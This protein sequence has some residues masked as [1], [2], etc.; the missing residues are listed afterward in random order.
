MCIILC[1]IFSGNH[2]EIELLRPKCVDSLHS[3]SPNT[4]ICS[5]KFL[6]L[7]YI[8]RPRTFWQPFCIAILSLLLLLFYS[9]PHRIYFIFFV[10][11]ARIFFLMILFGFRKLNFTLDLSNFPPKTFISFIFNFHGTHFILFA[12]LTF[13]QKM[14]INEQVLSFRAFLYLLDIID[15]IHRMNRLEILWTAVRWKWDIR[16]I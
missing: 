15:R 6:L 9:F 12:S 2:A 3:N 5:R 8:V 4:C 7:F 14:S 16:K 13:T 10:L 11:V 1:F